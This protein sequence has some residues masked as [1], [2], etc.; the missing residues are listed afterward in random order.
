MTT[1]TSAA[2]AQTVAPTSDPA[3]AQAGA[4]AKVPAAIDNTTPPAPGDNIRY[5]YVI[6]QA[7]ELGGHIADYSGSGAVYDTMVNLQSGPR[8]LNQSLDMHAVDPFKAKLFD[9][10]TTSSFGYAGDPNSV[11]LLNISKGKIYDFRGSFRRDR[12]YF[13]YDLLA[14]PLIPPASTPF[15]PILDSP[16]LYNTVRRMTDLNL[17]L[18]PLSRVSVRFGYN[19]SISEGPSYSSV[20][21]GTEALLTQ[22]WRNMTDSWTGGLDWRLFKHTTV[23]YDEFVTNYKGDTTWGLGGLNYQLSN[24]TPVSLGIDISSVWK[25]PCAAPF[26]ST[27]AVNPTCNAFLSYS[28]TAPTRTLMPSEQLRFQS[29]D[30]PHFTFNGRLLYSG[31]TANLNNFN[32]TFNG[33]ESRTTLRE[34]VV[35][36]SA[37]ARRVDVNGDLGVTW[38]ITPTVTATNL[39][40]FWNFRVPGRNNLSETDY[41]GASLLATPV[42]SPNPPAVTADSEFLNQ[43]TKTNTFLVAWDA[44]S[45]ARVSLGYRYRSRIITDA[46][47]DFIPIHENWGLFGSALRPS[48]QWRVNFDVD[49]MYAD[50]AFTRIS[51]RHME[52]YRLRSTYKPQGWLTLSGAINIRESSDNVQTVN[53]LEHNRDFSVGASI[54]PS[55]KWSLDMNYG[56]DSVYSSTIECYASTPAPPNASTAPDVCVAAGTP[57]ASTGYYNAPTQFGSLAFMLAPVKRV[58]LNGGYRMSAVNGNSDAINLRQVNGSLQSQYQSPY[59]N[60]VMDIQKNW[61]WKADYNYFGYGEGSPIGPTAPRN[62]RG[63]LYT[64]SVNYAF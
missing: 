42:I 20:H 48:P 52:H 4:P 60:V 53:H 39:F 57:F 14:N 15:L 28:R 10:L 34:S 41:L 31:A 21:F 5:G 18:A 1:D 54:A 49:A 43:K 36:G 32:E 9:T 2:T 8:V 63:N 61:S 22:D 44:T 55:E 6:H 35:T 50:N 7:L 33:L 25:T 16:H 47:G 27:G 40:N 45:R 26:T 3:T 13:D 29:A 11:S 12:Q 30:V 51:P 24:G 38:Q 59:A 56:Y 37:N 58:H 62:F 64:L 23:S 46:G 17:T 19:H